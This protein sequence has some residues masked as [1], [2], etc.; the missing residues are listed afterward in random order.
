MQ[1]KNFNVH[2]QNYI[3]HPPK[4][5]VPYGN[6]IYDIY[7]ITYV[8]YGLN[9][10]GQNIGPHVGEKDWYNILCGKEMLSIELESQ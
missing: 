5:Y 2:V 4:W 8:T 9:G 6:V 7:V 3:K 1:S 10:A